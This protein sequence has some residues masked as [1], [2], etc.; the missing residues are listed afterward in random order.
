MW[1]AAEVK[2]KSNAGFNKVWTKQVAGSLKWLVAFLKHE[3]G[4]VARTWSV[5]AHLTPSHDVAVVFDA[6]PYGLGAVL[7]ITGVPVAYLMGRIIRHDEKR[8]QYM[9]G[10]HR[11]QQCWEALAILVALRAWQPMLMGRRFSW[12]LAVRG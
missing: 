9:A 8:Y 7:Y 4:E 2:R 1:A 11:G 10:D 3:T 12:K 6:S 5:A